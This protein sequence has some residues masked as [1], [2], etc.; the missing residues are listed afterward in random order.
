MFMTTINTFTK[1]VMLKESL[2]YSLLFLKCPRCGQ[3]KIQEAEL[4]KLSNFNK[5]RK[6]WPTCDIKYPI[7]PSFYE[8]SMCVYYGLGVVVAIYILT[9]FLGQ[10]YFQI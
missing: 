9:M 2:P 8:G 7:E 10:I 1:K 6:S 5:V 3:G 4:Y